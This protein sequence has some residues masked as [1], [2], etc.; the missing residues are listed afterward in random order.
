MYVRSNDL[1]EGDVIRIGHG[2]E[3]RRRIT[4][5]TPAKNGVMAV[6]VA[7]YE[8]GAPAGLIIF[9]RGYRVDRASSRRGGE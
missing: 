6:A 4:Q 7:D 2:P 1:L 9:P 5:V 3:S 8:S